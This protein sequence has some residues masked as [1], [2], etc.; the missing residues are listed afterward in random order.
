[1]Q[2]RS[3]V[4][5]TGM[6]AAALALALAG[7]AA[8][9]PAPAAESRAML[10]APQAAPAA[11]QESGGDSSTSQGAAA[12]QLTDRLIIRNAELALVV[13]DTA[14]QLNAI[15]KMADELQ[16][17]I[18]SSSTTQYDEGLQAQVTMRVP[19]DRLDEALQRLRGLAVEVRSEQISGEDVTAEYT[20]L[21]AR[22]KNLEAAE[23]QLREILA[24]AE[25][26]EDVLSVF[27]Q[28]TQVRGEIESLKGRMQYL[29]QSAA[30]ATIAVTLIPDALAQPVQVA[31]WR[32]DGVAKQ[33]FEALIAALQSLASIAVWL[34][35]VVAPVLLILASPFI[36]V[37]L[38]I[39]RRRAKRSQKQE[40]R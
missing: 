24:K 1:M 31:G 23:T 34:V 25:K 19:A 30:L 26:T 32:L 14:A 37:Y 21:N 5:R 18:A 38:F 17:Y 10:E 16:G 6:L 2:P 20:D 22:L 28:L 8:A 11:P 39:R 7:C 27:N 40:A 3:I 29:S 36:I 12:N 9:A 33:A 35:I 15:A 4:R 13:Q